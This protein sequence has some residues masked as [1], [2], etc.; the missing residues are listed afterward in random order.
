MAVPV[1]LD[2]LAWTRRAGGAARARALTQAAGPAAAAA[3]D[4]SRALPRPETLVATPRQRLDVWD[5]P[6]AARPDLGGAAQAGAAVRGGG[7]PAARRSEARAARPAATNGRNCGADAA[8]VAAPAAGPATHLDPALRAAAA[9]VPAARPD[10]KTA[11]AGAIRAANVRRGTGADRAMGAT[12]GGAGASA[13]GT[14]LPRNAETWLCRGARRQRRGDQ[15]GRRRKRR[16]GWR[17]NSPMGGW[18]WAAGLRKHRAKAAK[19]PE[20]GSLF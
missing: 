12:V 4:L 1:R 19:K 15:Q 16:L 5:G 11:V 18:R 9:R 3:A 6:A 2:L 13:P 17:S 7:P 10:P 8:C 20:Q 14:W